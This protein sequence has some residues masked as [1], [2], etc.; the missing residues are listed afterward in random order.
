MLAGKFTP[1]C[2]PNEVKFLFKTPAK[3]FAKLGK[4]IPKNMSVNSEN[5]LIIP[6]M[7]DDE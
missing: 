6:M 7:I 2:F 4:N 3:L 1:D 5:Q